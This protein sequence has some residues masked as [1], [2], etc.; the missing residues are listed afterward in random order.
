V[1][2]LTPTRLAA[3]GALLAVLT[4]QLWISPHNPPGSITSSPD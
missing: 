2:V 1:H 4:F 3:A